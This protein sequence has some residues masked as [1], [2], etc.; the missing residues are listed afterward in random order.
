VPKQTLTEAGKDSLTLELLQ[1][2]S[3]NEDEYRLLGWGRDLSLCESRARSVVLS[4][5]D[6]RTN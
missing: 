4:K 6:L 2:C 5:N 3:L 1:I